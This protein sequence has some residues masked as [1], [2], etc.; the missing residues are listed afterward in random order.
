MHKFF[1]TIAFASCFFL[2]SC[3]NTA[4]KSAETTTAANDTATIDGHP[5]WIE[6]GNIYEVNI[7]QYT[8]EGT[9]KAF[10]KNLDRLKEMGVQT[11]WF[12]PI[13]PI[14]KKD[15]KG[16]LGSYYAVSDYVAINPEY[17]TMDDWKALVKNAHDKGFKVIIDWVPNH[18]GA[19]HPWLTTH[20]DFY[21]TDSIT[22]QPISPFD[23]TDVRKLNYKNPQL[24]DSMIASMKFWITNSDIDG[25]RCD[26]AG[27]VPKEFWSKCIADLKKAKNIF[28]L[29][30]SNDAWVHEAGFDASYPWDA[31]VAMKQ[32]AKGE[33]PAFAIDSVLW[34]VD[35]T[36]TPNALR[37]Y[38][39]SNHDENSWNK[40]D[41][42]TMPGASHA[43]FAVLTQTI[44]RS[45]PLI[46]SGQEEPFLDSLSFF[47]KDTISFGKYQRANFYKT[48]LNLRKNNPALAA[49]ASFKKLR[50]NN[51]AAIYAFEREKNGNK[52]LVILNLSKT[53][54]NFTWTDQPSE[55]EWNNVFAGSKEPVDK[56]FGIEPWG[57]VV[58][59]LAASGK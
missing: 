53:P 30:E 44:A 22:H 43:P 40:A 14:S 58:Y 4:T 3:N 13:N 56:G 2:L 55:K 50:T 28:M 57:Y 17:G 11:L 35:S 37:M 32:V 39:T 24:V 7:R 12:M 15:R 5:A 33:R 18:T 1:A 59:Q 51:D 52:V 45:V 49:N 54:Q 36:Y 10:E 46:Y 48:L 47:Y 9:F 31:F 21:E 25:F 34:R 26:V 38:F 16:V 27:S 29:A 41:Y 23:W 6:Q 8:P 42:G 20:P 19:D